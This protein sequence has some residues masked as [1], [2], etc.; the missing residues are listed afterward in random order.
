MMLPLINASRFIGV[1]VTGS[2]K[3]ETIRKIAAKS[4]TPPF[5]PA[6]NDLPILGVR[7]L[8]GE[9]RWYLDFAACPDVAST[10]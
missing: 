2:G 4:D 5:S 8:G 10:S 1:M 6:A 3:R 7:P 9:L